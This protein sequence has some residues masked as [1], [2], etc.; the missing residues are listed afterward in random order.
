[1]NILLAH[2]RKVPVHCYGGTERVFWDLAKALVDLGHSVTLLVPKGS[3]C[4]FAQVVF[5]DTS[6][7]DAKN[8]LARK[9]ILHVHGHSELARYANCPSL[10]TCHGN[11][12]PNSRIEGNV[13]FVSRN[14]AERHGSTNWVHNGIDFEQHFPGLPT[15]ADRSKSNRL[16]FLAKA[17]WRVKNLKGAVK[18]SRLA[19]MKLDVMGGHRLNL[20]MGFRF[21][22][23]LSVRFWGD[24][25]NLAKSKVMQTSRG[26][27]FPVTWHEPFGLAVVESLY[28]GCPVFATPYGSLTE[29]IS[30]DVGCLATSAEELSF[31]IQTRNFSAVTCH[32]YAKSNFS[33]LTMAKR[34]IELYERVLSG[35]V[36]SMGS[37]SKSPSRGLAWVN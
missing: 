31:A 3:R 24:V 9:D 34:Y 30:E 8:L 15:L 32:Q 12:L 1:M 7:N 5:D 23:W 27:V 25:D 6:P 22:P 19:G 29:L 33:S 16:H 14:H 20:N 11:L 36:L 10:L 26:L 28:L 2:S 21:T 4:D 37:A 13:V 17:A 35:E 18:V